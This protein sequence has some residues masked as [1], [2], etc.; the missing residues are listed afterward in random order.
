MHPEEGRDCLTCDYCR[1]KFFPE[2]NAD[3]IRI[4][5]EGSG[6]ECPVC[7]V[8]LADAALARHRILYCTHC[9]GSLMPMRVFTS[10]VEDLRAQQSGE[11]QM[12]RPPD[13]KQLRRTIHCPRCHRAMDT[14]YYGGPGNIIID[15]CSPCELNWLDS[16][17]LMQVVRAPDSFSTAERDY[18][19]NT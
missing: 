12:P 11:W 2:R 6:L 3:G 13:P 7:A 1:T 9:R 19:R 4:L 8:P 16:G 5:A 18:F 10:L 14:H 15:D 17:E